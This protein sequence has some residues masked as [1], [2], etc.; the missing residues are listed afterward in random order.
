MA[1]WVQG[2]RLIP[3]SQVDGKRNRLD[4]WWMVRNRSRQTFVWLALIGHVVVTAMVWRDLRRRPASQ[5]RGGKNLW[6]VL[7]ALNT[8]N[9]LIYVLVGRRR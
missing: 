6:R 3:A 1:F 9:S 5:L 8:G 2:R 7:S 4:R